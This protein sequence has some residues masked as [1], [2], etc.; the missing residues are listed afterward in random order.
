MLSS[1]CEQVNVNGTVLEIKVNTHKQDPFRDWS[2]G[3]W[4]VFE[5]HLCLKVKEWESEDFALRGVT[6][7]EDLKECNMDWLVF[8]DADLVF[9]PDFLHKLTVILPRLEKTIGSNL[10]TTQRVELD[11]EEVNLALE[12]DGYTDVIHDTS[13]TCLRIAIDKHAKCDRARGAGY[14]QMIYMPNMKGVR[15]IK[16]PTVEQVHFN[17][18]RDRRVHG[19]YK[20][21]MAFRKNCSGVLNGLGLPPI[22]HL[23][24][25]RNSERLEQPY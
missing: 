4:E 20:A 18:G 21:D 6:R 19:H 7:N 24:H 8:A 11:E 5:P 1:L 14:F 13:T 15:Y 25:D 12:H 22:W 16:D 10:L 9:D 23:A 17:V 2:E 3:M